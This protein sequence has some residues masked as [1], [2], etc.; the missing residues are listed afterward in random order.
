[1]RALPLPGIAILVNKPGQKPVIEMRDGCRD[2]ARTNV[3]A[4]TFVAS[5]FWMRCACKDHLVI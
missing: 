4:V 1:M 5:L 3:F 2:H